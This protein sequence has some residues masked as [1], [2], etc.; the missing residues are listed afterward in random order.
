MSEGVTLGV[1]AVFG[2]VLMLAVLLVARA[3]SGPDGEE[4]A[5]EASPSSSAPARS[6][7]SAG[8]SGG[9]SGFGD[10][11]PSADGSGGQ[12]ESTTTTTPTEPAPDSGA[13][14]DQ[15][16][17]DDRSD[18]EPLDCPAGVDPV[19][20]DAAEFVQLA[21]GRP[22][23][24]FPDVELLEDAEFDREL[25]ADFEDYRDDYDVDEVKLSALGLLDPELSLADVVR[26]SLEVGVVGFYD[27]ETGQLVVRGDDLDLYVQLVLVH[28]LAH[29]FDDQWFDLNRSDFIDDD[30]D[31]GFS[32]V[33]EGNASRVEGLWRDQLPSHDE[34]ILNREE[35]LALSPEDLDR[36][37]TLPPVVQDLQF[38][39][40]VDGWRYASALA[41][42][43][44][45]AAIDEALTEPPSGSELVLHPD[46]D[47]TADPEIEVP[48]PP[49]DGTV[50][51][52]GRI[53]ELLL[54][55]WLG[56]SPAE[57]WGG[58]RYVTWQADGLDCIRVDLVGDDDRETD[59]V[60]VA[61]TTWAGLLPSAR[62]VDA[63]IVG[64]RP[65]VRV[66]ACH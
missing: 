53:G 30:A 49:A 29:A 12:D 44:G 51:D 7:P 19:I 20:C 32:A 45:E 27:P 8:G 25:L 17:P 55:L 5:A 11:P 58:D 1:A 42:A 16:S 65:A 62:A 31:Y 50:V 33:V 57:G 47:R 21:R 24:T 56:R 61:A 2:A 35:A 52:D 39:P 3:T 46:I 41:G 26:D 59:E 48:V 34:A 18:V 10:L 54:R 40:Y 64:G 6:S 28:E 9:G 60:S 15:P 37:L 43:G 38:S 63:T 22:F 14:D 23:R 66:T 4:T 36:L 13:G